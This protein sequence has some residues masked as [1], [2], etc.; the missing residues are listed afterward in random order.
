MMWIS[1]FGVI[2]SSTGTCQVITIRNENA[3]Q[4]SA[5]YRT[6]RDRMKPAIS[7]AL[8]R[9]HQ[10]PNT[11]SSCHANGLKYQFPPGYEGRFQSKMRA[12]TYRT[13]EPSRVQRGILI[14]PQRIAGN[15]STSTI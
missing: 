14:R 4:A 13:A 1:H 7:E 10:T 5:K 8:P 15:A 11:N 12:S 2:A 9:P 6:A 3:I